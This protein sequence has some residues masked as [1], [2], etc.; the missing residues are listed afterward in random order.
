[1]VPVSLLYDIDVV[2]RFK[3]LDPYNAPDAMKVKEE[4]KEH[5][6]SALGQDIMAIIDFIEGGEDRSM[7]DARWVWMYG[8][9]AQDTAGLLPVKIIEQYLA[10]EYYYGDLPA[11]SLTEEER[12]FYNRIRDRVIAKENAE[13]I[14][15]D[16]KESA[17]FRR[18]R[19]FIITNT[20]LEGGIPVLENK[21]YDICKPHLLNVDNRFKKLGARL[22]DE[23]AALASDASSV[24]PAPRQSAAG[25]E[26]NGV[27]SNGP[28]PKD[29]RLPIA[30]SIVGTG[31]STDLK[32]ALTDK[33]ETIYRAIDSIMDEADKLHKENNTY[34]PAIPKGKLLCHI[35]DESIL[36]VGQRR[37]LNDL[38]RDMKSPEYKEKIVRL[39]EDP[40]SYFIDKVKA[41]IEA[42]KKQYEGYEIE[43]DI[44]CPD[45]K[46]VEE[47]LNSGL[48]V[49]G[50]AFR[51]YVDT[52]ADVVQIEGIMLALR[53]LHSNDLEKLKR[54][55]EFLGNTLSE[56][57]LFEIKDI[58]T[59]IKTAVFALP[60]A[61]IE[62][63]NKAKKIHDLIKKN[64]EQAA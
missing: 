29:A 28:S 22:A 9:L 60:H 42:L 14:W 41:K 51:P 34:C 61:K 32:T 57:R 27:T 38:D 46:T 43:F 16:I 49:R 3:S 24:P 53:A 58:D 64:I 40:E 36:P 20:H 48:G 21:F 59:F 37:M 31:T 12:T 30:L 26:A 35:I 6:A 11:I 4:L 7:H 15:R 2:Y 23:E 5:I 50:L 56:H 1:M 13:Y 18:I 17:R 25:E 39:E 63:Y 52:E 47:V 19:D 45:T 62:D 8:Y 33:H 54:A 55:F 10:F 44:A